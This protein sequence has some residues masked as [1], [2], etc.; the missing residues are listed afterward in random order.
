MKKIIHIFSKQFFYLFTF[1]FAFVFI[2]SVLSFFEYHFG[3]DIPLVKIEDFNDKLQAF[4]SLPFTDSVIIYPITSVLP[5]IS[6]L[7]TL[8]YYVVFFYVLK[9]FF[10]VFTIEKVFTENS[11]KKLKRFQLINSIAIIAALV[12]AV[13]GAVKYSRIVFDEEH[14]VLIVHIFVAFLIYFYIDLIKKGQRLQEENDLT[15]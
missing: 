6:L 7:V 13:I 4:V 3:W 15:I 2:F 10:A 11:L 12:L 14:L 8:F 1:V 5:V 9:D